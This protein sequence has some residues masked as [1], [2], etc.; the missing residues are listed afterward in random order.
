MANRYNYKL[1]WDET[2]KQN[3]SVKRQGLCDVWVKATRIQVVCPF[4]TEFNNR[5]VMLSG[6]W[7]P[8]SGVWTFP[9][10]AQPLV[11]ELCERCWP[12]KVRGI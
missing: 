2:R 7:R 8:R 3:E 5:A 10:K 1:K 6:K 9:R 11:V 4:S 12:G